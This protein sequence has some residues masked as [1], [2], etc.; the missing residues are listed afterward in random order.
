[1]MEPLD[2][3]STGDEASTDSPPPSLSNPQEDEAILAAPLLASSQDSPDSS[4]NAADAGA[5]ATSAGGTTGT[6]GAITSPPGRPE[7]LGVRRNL[8]RSRKTGRSPKRKRRRGVRLYN[9]RRSSGWGNCL[10]RRLCCFAQNKVVRCMN[11]TARVVLWST[12]IALSV[13]VIWYSYE[14]FHRGYVSR[15]RKGDTARDTHK[16]TQSNLLAYPFFFFHSLVSLII[17]S[18]FLCCAGLTHILL[19][20]SVPEPLYYWDFPLVCGVL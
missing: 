7:L 15:E 1:M 20:G 10:L 13:G 4:A 5:V 9:N 17:L 11:L 6:P 12:I 16:R 19:R 18:I 2:T 3:Q 14:L 8:V